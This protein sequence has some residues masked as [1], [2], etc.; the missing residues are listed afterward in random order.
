MAKTYSI[1]CKTCKKQL[2]IGQ[3]DYIYKGR[4]Y[5]KA[6]ETFLFQ[7]KGHELLFD[8]NVNQLEGYEEVGE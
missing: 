6:L 4:D 2:W 3:R 8:D 1:A 7:H 5:I